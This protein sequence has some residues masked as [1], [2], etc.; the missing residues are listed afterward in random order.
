MVSIAALFLPITMQAAQPT[1]NSTEIIFE[2]FQFSNYTQAF[3]LANSA[4]MPER[5]KRKHA[6]TSEVCEGY[7]KCLN[8]R[9]TVKDYL[10]HLILFE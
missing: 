7:Q 1:Y 6:K 8:K 4:D 5:V 3:I 10:N 9:I 2:N